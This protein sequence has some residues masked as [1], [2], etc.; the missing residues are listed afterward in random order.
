MIALTVSLIWI[1]VLGTIFLLHN[2]N[3]TRFRRDGPPTKELPFL[4]AIH[5]T[6]H[7]SHTT[8]RREERFIKKKY[9]TF[10]ARL[11]EARKRARTPGTKP[12]FP[13]MLLL[14]EL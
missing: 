2:I 12:F 5:I 13:V 4:P 11:D 9:I 8:T 10:I 7:T 6:S 1:G 3:I 14:G